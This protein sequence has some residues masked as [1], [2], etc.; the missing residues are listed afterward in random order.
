MTASQLRTLAARS[1]ARSVRGGVAAEVAQV[2]TSAASGD[3]A[4]WSRRALEAT[5]AVK[6]SAKRQRGKS[7]V[8]RVTPASYQVA[9]LR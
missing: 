2:K 7:A 5:G 3:I 9:L 4:G 6:N 8:D 1:D